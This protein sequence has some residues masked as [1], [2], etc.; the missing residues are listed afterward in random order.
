MPA[1]SFTPVLNL[2]TENLD[3]VLPA[4]GG[5]M[6]GKE[7]PEVEE[8]GDM[9]VDRESRVVTEY[10]EPLPRIIQNIFKPALLNFRLERH[11]FRINNRLLSFV[12]D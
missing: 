12:G 5:A 8:L 1:L 11:S 6:E 7:T 10:N 4:I 9:L 2:L 3:N